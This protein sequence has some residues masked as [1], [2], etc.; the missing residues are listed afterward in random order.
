M[1]QLNRMSG[2]SPSTLSNIVMIT[3]LA[4]APIQSYAG[5]YSQPKAED[6]IIVKKASQTYSSIEETQTASAEAMLVRVFERMNEGSKPLD[7]DFARVLSENILD[8]F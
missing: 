4:T 5:Y 8:L 3:A 2:N 7:D 1:N 6:H